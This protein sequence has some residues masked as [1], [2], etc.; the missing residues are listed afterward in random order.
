[1]PRICM[2]ICL[3]FFLI[4][5]NAQSLS[6]NL[7]DKYNHYKEQTIKVKRFKHKDI[8]PLIVKLRSNKDFD[9]SEVGKSIENR[10]IYQIKYGSGPV[11]I[12][13]WSQMHGNESTATMALFDIFNLLAGS[14][15]DFDDFRKEISSV[16]TLY[17][18]PMLNPDGAEKWQRRTALEIDMNRDAL[19]LVCPESRILKNLQ[20]K[21]LPEFGF[22][23][24]DQ[25]PRV[26]AGHSPNLATISFLA[27]AYNYDLDI[28]DSRIRSM[29]LIAD[30]NGEMQRFIP[31]QIARYSDDHEPR[32]F[33]DN[34]QKWGTSLVLI[35]SGGYKNDPEKMYIRKLNY[36]AILS[37]FNSIAK[38]IYQQKTIADY[39]IIPKNNNYHYDLIVRNVSIN[40]NGQSFKADIGIS[41]NEVTSPD[42]K[43]NT[44]RSNIADI[45][46]L[47]T[48][49]GIEE[50]DAEGAEIQGNTEKPL[51]LKIGMP[52]TFALSKNGRISSRLKNGFWE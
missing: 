5:G 30:I 25:D 40:V 21:Y 23:L 32:A 45:G 37:A 13:L 12:L 49:F 34:I 24:H 7:F 31:D 27:P 36:V 48:Y 35:E 47:S 4:K 14:N 41:R 26:S 8:V 52:A 1:M 9:I 33:G 50:I 42:F 16:V 29:Q 22:N 18:V 2:L 10:T 15:D 20:Q 11:K 39:E 38:N 3:C 17:F 28:N 19:R 46:D 43:S 44:Y 51:A 6:K